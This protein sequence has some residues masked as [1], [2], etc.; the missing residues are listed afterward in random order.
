MKEMNTAL[1]SLPI[2]TTVSLF[3][4]EATVNNKGQQYSLEKTNNT[5]SAHL[6]SIVSN[7]VDWNGGGCGNKAK[8]A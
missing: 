8:L 1:I 7:I 5:V 2:E 3:S 4:S 6:S